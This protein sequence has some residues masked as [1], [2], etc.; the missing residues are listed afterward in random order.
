MDSLSSKLKTSC[1]LPF[2]RV[3]EYSSAEPQN[4]SPEEINEQ[5]LDQLV[6]LASLSL[7]EFWYQYI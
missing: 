2:N 6:T 5:S 7:F 3:S 1:P 4:E